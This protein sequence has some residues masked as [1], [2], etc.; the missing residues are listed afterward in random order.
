[1]KSIE[2]LEEIAASN[3]IELLSKFIKS[4]LI[5][6]ASDIIPETVISVSDI[7]NHLKLK[8]KHE[9]SNLLMGKIANLGIERNNL[10]LFSEQ[11]EIL[12]YKLIQS[13]M[14]EG[15]PEN[16]AIRISTDK[17]TEICRKINRIYLIDLILASCNFNTPQEVISKF[18]RENGTEN[19]YQNYGYS[20]RYNYGNVK[21]DNSNK[22]KI[23]YEN[24]IKNKMKNYD[25]EKQKYASLKK[26]K[27][28]KEKCITEFENDMSIKNEYT[29]FSFEY[30]KV[31]KWLINLI[32]YVISIFY[33]T[34]NEVWKMFS[35]KYNILIKNSIK[36]IMYAKEKPNKNIPL[37]K[38]LSGLIKNIVLKHTFIVKEL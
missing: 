4:K 14:E 36:N 17:T 35:R 20:N 30:K 34:S 7:K 13:L 38:S 28:G 27:D 24:N 25:H 15:L 16:I 37:D 6:R 31:C 23:E 9:S 22:T 32:F 2:L 26:Y 1:M 5:N 8:I 3:Q 11:L 21:I 29:D 33:I 18:L 19:R 10:I 12:S